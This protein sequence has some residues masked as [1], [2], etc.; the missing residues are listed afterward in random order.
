MAGDTIWMEV[1]PSLAN[2]GKKLSD[3]TDKAAK[4]S[5]KTAGGAWSQA[6]S[7]SAGDSGS[8]AVVAQIEA[9]E[10]KARKAVQASTAEIGKARASHREASAR[11]VDAEA[12][13]QAAVVKSE[14]ASGKSAEAQAQAQAKVESAALR[15]EA[16]REKERVAAGKVDGAEESLKA[17]YAESEEASKQLAEAN[18]E[19]GES[20]D[21]SAANAEDAKGA[22]GG[23]SDTWKAAIGIA[24]A[25]GTAFVGTGVALFQ[26]GS[27]FD[28]VSDT[29]RVGTGATGEALDSLVDSAKLVGTN[30]PNEFEEVGTTI[31]DVNTRLGL[32][33]GTLETVASQYLQAG[34]ILGEAVDIQ[35][36]T[37]AF[38]AFQIEGEGV[39]DAMDTLFV[40]SQATGVGM[41]DLADSVSKNA[42]ALQNL[43][44]SFEETTALVGQLDKAGLDADATLGAMSKGLVTLA[45]DGEEPQEAFRRVTDEIQGMID[46]GDIASAIDLASGVFGTRAANQFVGAVQD[47]TMA[48]DDLVDATGATGDTILGVADET[49]DFSEQWQMFKNGV[50]VELEPVAS[51]VFGVIT[52]AMT[53]IKDDG[54]PVIKNL[55]GWLTDHIGPAFE[56]V[57][58]WI[59]DDAVPALKSFGGWIVDNK[60]WILSIAAAVGSVV[61]AWALWKGAIGAWQTAT[62]IA[63]GV[64]VAFN[65]VMNANPVMLV[66]TAIAALVGGLTYF[67]TQTETGR[68]V[69]DTFTTAL[70]DAWQWVCDKLGEGWEWI[71]E[72][73]FEPVKTGIG[74]VADKFVEA[75]DWAVGA[76]T[77][78]GDGLAAGWQWTKDNVFTPIGDAAQWVVDKFIQAKDWVVDTWTAM[79]DGLT[80]GWQWVKDN[81]FTPITDG[82]QSIW[83]KFVAMKDGAISAWDSLT[84]RLLDIWSNLKTNLFE[85]VVLAAQSIWDKFVA[86][87][88][89]SISVW[90][91]LKDTL[92]IIYDQLNLL[93]FQPVI[94]VAQGILD[95]F[96]FVKDGVVGAWNLMKDGLKSGWDWINTNIFSKM[97][98]GVAKVGDAFD[99]AKE[100]IGTAWNQIKEKTREPVNFVIQTVYNDGV[101]SA[102]NTIA[103]KVGLPAK[104]R[105]PHVQKVATGGVL[106]GY[107]PGVDVHKFYSDTAGILELSGG[108]AIMRPEFTRAVGGKAGV[109]AINKA[110]ITG[111]MPLA[112]YAGGGVFDTLGGWAESAWNWTKDAAETTW[113]FLSNPLE[114]FKKLVTAPMNAILGGLE[115]NTWAQIAAGIPKLVIG[116][117]VDSAVSA[118][119]SLF[120]AQSASGVSGPMMAGG[121]ALPSRGPITSGYGP[122]WGSFHAGTDIAGGGPTFAAHAGRVTRAGWNPIAGRTGIGI[123]VDHGGGIQTYYGHNPVGGVRVAPG[124]MVKAGQHIGYQ[125][126]TGNVTGTHLHFEVHRG[127]PNA[128]TN[129]VPFMAARGVKLG[130]Y[131]VGGTLDPGL[132]LAFNGTGK[133]ETIRTHEQEQAL[134]GDI[135]LSPETIRKLSQA[136]G[137]EL[138]L[139]GETVRDHKRAVTMA[140]TLERTQ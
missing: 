70:G 30:V 16:A 86:M 98:E 93:V 99:T 134:G 133:P 106:P 21:V 135:D 37:A 55:A 116:G 33:G 62:K 107:T 73:V 117:V 102:F 19:L 103:D 31:A 137:E 58:S 118:V 29:I 47:G 85:P 136:I 81:V 67:F 45:K 119:K 77:A 39:V 41:N 100:A 26:V 48:L 15:L 63:T 54:I 53:W 75:K 125:G 20:T 49:A 88:D 5:G 128:I 96:V 46:K 112:K 89:G 8:K 51:R 82:V 121:W 43:G 12:R 123:L 94:N 78:M 122:R 14:S 27:V 24:A 35:K 34:N 61:G 84:T 66:V 79:G 72:N 132:T 104:W 59:M 3:E 71:N 113:N 18:T 83:D 44:F 40:I 130:T 36:T 139:V 56:N 10:A 4:G 32:T 28:D 68:K 6:F 114:G 97:K 126:A 124:Q 127:N 23:L 57:A 64:Q 138:G 65:A 22:W 95:K 80:S 120:E 108:E 101:R 92:K 76:W 111:T 38:S 7:Q 129:P 131:D 13:Y 91:F 109:A 74:W 17:A 110:A 90:T 2:F 11:V 1:L 60:D 50:L 25:A 115:S 87:K 42:P 105:L 9:N 52:D 140:R 69:W